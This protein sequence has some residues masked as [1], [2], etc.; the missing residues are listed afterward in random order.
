MSEGGCDSTAVWPHF[1]VPGLLYLICRAATFLW[2]AGNLQA[3]GP[4]AGAEASLL[5]CER[6]IL[7]VVIAYANA[8]WTG[9]PSVQPNMPL[10]RGLPSRS[11]MAIWDQPFGFMDDTR[12]RRMRLVLA[13]KTPNRAGGFISGVVERSCLS[14]EACMCMLLTVSQKQK[15]TPQQP[16]MKR[17][18]ITKHGRQDRSSFTVKSITCGLGLPECLAPGLFSPAWLPVSAAASL[19]LPSPRRPPPPRPP[20]TPP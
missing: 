20:Q 8:W 18:S 3:R 4:G 5:G 13:E 7:D 6:P 12:K 14:C 16:Y 2:L 19:P 15:L 9:R 1:H 17:R 11:S 10:A